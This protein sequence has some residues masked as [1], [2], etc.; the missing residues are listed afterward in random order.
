M[1]IRPGLHPKNGK[2]IISLWQIGN[3]FFRFMLWLRIQVHDSPHILQQVQFLRKIPCRFPD[4][5]GFLTEPVD[6]KITLFKGHQRK[7][8]SFRNR[9]IR[10][11]IGD[12]GTSGQAHTRKCIAQ[13][14]KMLLNIPRALESFMN[15]KQRFFRILY[16]VFLL[17][18][19]NNLLY[20]FPFFQ[21]KCALFH[22]FLP[23][24][25][26]KKTYKPILT[27]LII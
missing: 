13:R 7:H 12:T 27:Q 23:S 1:H 15:N 10:F 4:G 21:I 20:R 24:V 17:N 18:G 3:K 26:C 2:L 9:S 22:T 6:V 11:Q 8:R 14:K 25:C 19:L 16:K 5:N